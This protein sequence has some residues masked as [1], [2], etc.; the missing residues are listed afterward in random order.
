MQAR[1]R[2]EETAG[3]GVQAPRRFWS[4]CIGGVKSQVPTVPEH[5]TWMML[6]RT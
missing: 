3:D 6:D 4:P 1:E 2:E 5:E